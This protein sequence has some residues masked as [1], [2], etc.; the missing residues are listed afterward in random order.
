MFTVHPLYL[1]FC[2]GDTLTGGEE[3]LIYICT[4]K[5]W[6][7]GTEKSP[8][9]RF[10]QAQSLLMFPN[11]FLLAFHKQRFCPWLSK[12]PKTV[13]L[14]GAA[15]ADGGTNS[16]QETSN[17]YPTVTRSYLQGRRDVSLHSASSTGTAKGAVLPRAAVRNFKVKFSEARPCKHNDLQKPFHH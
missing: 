6:L 10:I 3:L 15:M 14:K 1:T 7:I 5:P 16:I 9:L 13:L 8:T 12:I 4:I 11:K 17:I 2:P